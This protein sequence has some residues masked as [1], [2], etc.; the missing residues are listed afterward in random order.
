ML[1]G[2]VPGI[3]V[4]AVCK[5]LSTAVAIATVLGRVEVRTQLEPEDHHDDR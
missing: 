1:K 4:G 3:G 5:S 2:R